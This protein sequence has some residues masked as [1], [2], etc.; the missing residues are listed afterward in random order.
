MM[1]HTNPHTLYNS[2]VIL[3]FKI[4]RD[5]RENQNS[6]KNLLIPLI[7]M[8]IEQRHLV[9]FVFVLRTIK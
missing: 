4:I 3:I 6:I 5:P 1:T 2:D 8:W 7:A 9:V